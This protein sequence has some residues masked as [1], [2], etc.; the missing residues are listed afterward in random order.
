[1]SG[2]ASEKGVAGAGI[3]EIASMAELFLSGVREGVGEG[4][5]R[6]VRV[7]P[8]GGSGGMKVAEVERSSAEVGGGRGGAVWVVAGGHVGSAVVGRVLGEVARKLAG[9][10][11]GRRVGVLGYGE[12]RVRLGLVDSGLPGD[13]AEPPE[14]GTARELTDAAVEL[15]GE[16]DAWVVGTDDVRSSGVVVDAAGGVGGGVEGGWVVPVEA[17]ED[18]RVDAYRTIKSLAS[19]GGGAGVGR[20]RLILAAVGPGAMGVVG[21]LR[22]VMR[23]FLLWDAADALVVGEDAAGEVHPL[24]TAAMTGPEWGQ[25]QRLVVEG[26]GEAHWLGEVSAEPD[27]ESAAEPVK[28][29]AGPGKAVVAPVVMRSTGEESDVIELA[30][31]GPSGV[32]AAVVAASKGWSDCEVPVPAGVACRVMAEEGDS[33]G[34]AVLLAV[35]GSGDRELVQVGKAVGWLSEHLELV[36]RAARPV[37]VKPER[38]LRVVLYVPTALRGQLSGLVRAGVEVMGYRPLRWGGRLGVLV[39]AA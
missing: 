4:R 5:A 10:E 20:G 32:L 13:S 22:E 33:G 29:V 1:M 8:G 38:G 35:V 37:V 26:R 6:P 24:V 19:R 11:R 7:P 39:E 17:G 28:A 14:A 31:E 16:V 30:E 36:A 27:R 3:S 21:Q 18:G 25:V 23:K 12:G 34:T 2:Q 15:S 9:G